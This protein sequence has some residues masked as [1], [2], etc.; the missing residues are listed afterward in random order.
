LIPKPRDWGSYINLAGFFFLEG[1]S[2]YKPPK[3]LV[4][5]LDAGEPPVYIGFGSIVVD[6]PVALTNMIFTAVKNLGIRALVSKGWG[7]IGGDEVPEGVHLLGNVPHDWLF[8]KMSAVVHHGGAGTTAIS[9]ATGKPTVVVP[10]FGDQGFWGAMVARA[11]AGPDPIPFK[12]MTAETLTKSMQF[13]LKPETLE[14]AK[15]LANQ[16][17]NE[18]GTAEGARLF[19]ESLNL[20]NMRC[21]L[22]PKRVAVWHVKRTKLRLSAFAATVLAKN[23]LLKEGDLEIIH[24]K[25]WAVDEGPEGP[26]SGGV[27]ALVGS[28]TDFMLGVGHLSHSIAKASLH[29]L[30]H[31]LHILPQ[32]QKHSLD[33]SQEPNVS[34]RTRTNNGS[35]GTVRISEEARQEE[36]GNKEIKNDPSSSKK[37]QKRWVKANKNPMHLQSRRKIASV[38]PG[39][40]YN[41]GDGPSSIFLE[42]RR[43]NKLVR[44]QK[45]E[46]DGSKAEGGDRQE[47]DG[48]RIRAFVVDILETSGKITKVIVKLPMEITYNVANGFHNA[49]ILFL[50]DETVRKH[51]RITGVGSGL[52]AAGRVS[53]FLLYIT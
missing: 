43:R 1:A 36:G 49:P 38:F 45:K 44:Q 40:L 33:G 16:I 53:V 22:C 27:A 29:E 18:D 28:L 12:Q 19:C 20:D 11:G 50:G 30:Q 17:Q 42:K 4:D 52:V 23:G 35:D 15:E 5:F 39:L 7:G 34:E 10:F 9:I 6:D 37:G 41:K 21:M 8:P 46:E 24:H 47:S 48:K 25:E 26:L 51:Y 32:S 2:T 14:R 31:P 3:D 13:A